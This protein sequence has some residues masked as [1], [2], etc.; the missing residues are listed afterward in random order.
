MPILLLQGRLIQQMWKIAIVPPNSFDN[1][2]AP[3]KTGACLLTNG[4][5]S[6]SERLSLHQSTVPTFSILFTRAST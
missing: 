4:E 1:R 3:A 2:Q 6:G 5:H